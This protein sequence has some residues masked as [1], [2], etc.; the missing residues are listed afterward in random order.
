MA[1]ITV[2]RRAPEQSTRLRIVVGRKTGAGPLVLEPAM[3][4]ADIAAHQAASHV[5]RRTPSAA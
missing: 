4:A 5:R 2:A 3:S 1:E